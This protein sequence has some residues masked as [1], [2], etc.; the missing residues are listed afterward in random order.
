MR[1]GA[2]TVGLGVTGSG[3]G[4]FVVLPDAPIYTA[5][6]AAVNTPTAPEESAPAAPTDGVTL[7]SYD[8]EAIKAGPVVLC[9][10]RGHGVSPHLR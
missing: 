10:Q 8:I 6:K 4:A 1:K 7:S 2:T 5:T 3:N 9:L